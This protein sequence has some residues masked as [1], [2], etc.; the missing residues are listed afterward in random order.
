MECK[1]G[2]FGPGNMGLP[3]AVN[4]HK[5]GD[6]ITVYARR[7]EAA[8]KLDEY[9]VPYVRTPRELGGCEVFISVLTDVNAFKAVFDQKDGLAEG[10]DGSHK[11]LFDLSTSNPLESLP[12]YAELEEKYN[13]TCIDMP[14]SG[15]AIGSWENRLTYMA[16]GDKETYEKYK[17]IFAKIAK[18]MFYMGKS[19]CGQYT[20]ICHNQTSMAMI[21]AT[22]ESL[23]LGV[24]VG[25]DPSALIDVFN[26]GNASS[27]TTQF[28]YPQHIL[29]KKYDSGAT[30]KTLLKDLTIMHKTAELKNLDLPITTANW[31]Y[32]KTACDE[33]KAMD[34]YTSIY[35]HIGE[36]ARKKK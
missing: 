28:I 21:E 32:W 14:I 20:K 4:L 1:I 13:F 8:A 16:G 17:W 19:G 24:E 22:A 23:Q 26:S 30:M 35:E 33:G 6:D 10:L 5:L 3:I 12:I 25:I 27:Y 7:D 34:D 18:N 15:G 9:G 2:L 31:N 11:V 36:Y 29:N